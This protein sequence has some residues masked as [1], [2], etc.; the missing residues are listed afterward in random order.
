MMR[1]LTLCGSAG[2][3]ISKHALSFADQGGRMRMKRLFAISL[4]IGLSASFIALQTN[5]AIIASAQDAKVKQDGFISGCSDSVIDA[6]DECIQE[7][8]SKVETIFG[9]TRVGTTT[10][11]GH[12]RSFQAET[13]VERMVIANLEGS[14]LQVGFYLCGGSPHYTPTNP[15]G[16]LA[17]DGIRGPVVITPIASNWE[18]PESGKVW[19]E[20]K[21][22]LRSFKEKN[23]YEF[24]IENWKVAARP[25]RA[26]ESCLD[27]HIHKAGILSS[28]APEG[29]RR[30]KAGDVLGVAMYVY[31]RAR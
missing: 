31:A 27:C 7:R 30:L 15:E 18:L 28:D 20:T 2:A 9:I 1:G 12:K 5:P 16:I 24:A 22:A 26:R 21:N 11:K 6:L 23:Q 14:G 13:E 10:M 17:F 25:I 4:M 19:R 8:F 3:G 29:Y